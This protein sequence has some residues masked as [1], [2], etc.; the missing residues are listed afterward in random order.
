MKH[1]DI[2]RW[3]VWFLC[4]CLGMSCHVISRPVPREVERVERRVAAKPSGVRST[5]TAISFSYRWPEDESEE[6]TFYFVVP[7]GVSITPE[8]LSYKLRAAALGAR[9]DSG[10]SRMS[11]SSEPLLVET[12]VLARQISVKD[13]GFVRFNRLVEVRVEPRVRGVSAGQGIQLAEIEVALSF[14]KPY[15]TQASVIDNVLAESSWGFGRIL[16]TLV[17]N[18]EACRQY[19]TVSPP[20]SAELET[21]AWVPWTQARKGGPW[22]K[23]VIEKPGFYTIDQQFLQA[24]GLDPHTVHP[25]QVRIYNQGSKVPVH[26]AGGFAQTYTPNDHVVFYGVPSSSKYSGKN[27]YWVTL[28]KEHIGLEMPVVVQ[29]SGSAV[30]SQAEPFFFCSRVVEEDNELKMHTGRFLTIRE[31]QW[32]WK[33][34]TPDSPVTISFDLPGLYSMS[35]NLRIAVNLFFD[36]IFFTT[37][38]KVHCV[39]NGTVDADWVF[40]DI[41]DDQKY[42]QF[43][44]EA[45]REQGNTMRF[46]ETLEEGQEKPVRPAVYLDRIEFVYP[47]RFAAVDDAL[48]FTL[49]APSS[50]TVKYVRLT[51]FSSKPLL[52]FDITK[53]EQPQVIQ[54]SRH[55]DGSADLRIWV[56]GKRQ[57]EF[58]TLAQ[59][60]GAPL[61]NKPPALANLRSTMNGADYLIIAHENFLEVVNPLVVLK[62]AQ[63]LKTKLINVE[64]IYNEFNAGLESPVAIK[65]FLAYALRHWETRRPTYVLLVG[66]STSYYRG[67]TRNEAINYVPSFSYQVGA[68]EQDKWASDHWYTTVAGTDALADL[69]LGRLSVNSVED[70]QTVVE[71]IVHYSEQPRFGPWRTTLGYVADEGIFDRECEDLRTRYTPRTF[72]GETAYLGELPW[73][74]NFYLPL[75]MME[76]EKAKVSPIATARIL[77]MLNHGVL[78]LTFYGHGSPNVWTDEHIWFGGGSPNS[79][80]LHLRN[81]DV[82][83]FIINMTCNSG[84]IDYPVPPW[85]ICISEDFMRVKDGGAIGM[86]VPSGPGFTSTHKKV[87]ISLRQAFFYDGLRRLGDAIVS[88]NYSHLFKGHDENMVRMFILLGDPALELQVPAETCVLEVSE[89]VVRKGVSQQVEITGRTEGIN[90]GQVFYSVYTPSNEVFGEPVTESFA[91]G[92]LAYTFEVPETA[93]R[94]EWAVHAYCWNSEQGRDAMGAV[95]FA[96]DTPFVTLNSFKALNLPN[97]LNAGDLVELQ[98]TIQN[99]SAFQLPDVQVRVVQRSAGEEEKSQTRI[100]ALEPDQTQELRFH[101]TVAGGLNL[102]A[103]EVLNNVDPPDALT[104]TESQKTI[105]LG[106]KQAKGETELAVAGELCESEMTIAGARLRIQFRVPVF[107][108]GT[109]D[110]RGEVVLSDEE[111]NE[112]NRIARVFRASQTPHGEQVLIAT[113]ISPEQ[114]NQTL[115]F[116]VQME[117]QSG[118]E[119]GEMQQFRYTLDLR[120]LPDLVITADDVRFNNPNPTEGVTVF[121]HATVHNNGEA[122]AKDVRVTAYDGDP[123]GAGQ[124][125]ESFVHGDWGSLAYLAPGGSADVTLRWDPVKNVGEHEIFVKVDSSGRIS[126]SDESNNVASRPLRVKT[127]AILVPRGIIILEQT[128]EEREQHVARLAARVK[129]AGETAAHNVFVE[130]YSSYEQ[131]GENKLGQVII[132]EI[133]PAEIQMAIYRWQAREEDLHRAARPSYKIFLKGSL[134]RISSVDQEQ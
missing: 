86:Y 66:D 19:A 126:E 88:A 130:F 76:Q 123:E 12:P 28:D 70:A 36:P 127:K 30:P 78:F 117:D 25:R 133:R 58:L 71:K 40:A 21:Q 124:R 55:A 110:V 91:D 34:L 20:L 44:Y 5:A 94:G 49:D 98:A 77:D 56:Q 83:P 84:A 132:E 22:L 108:V 47:R 53:P 35:G 45:L 122:A 6:K 113:S 2:S 103:A 48:A 134:Q 50:G 18:P 57:Y 42:L 120:R 3:M 105:G 54:A 60:E 37:H 97:E 69:I 67:E 72:R 112:L 95:R 15:E 99:R 64:A 92:R 51:G 26:V 111:G 59:L 85:N 1:V 106:V 8:I 74:D 11:A 102:F 13:C 115:T 24:A 80:N 10:A 52:G 79:D 4:A 14:D 119:I 75:D 46:T 29:S 90:E 41:S 125:L 107:N 121:I 87:S 27:V 39:L 65:A 116:A 93:K 81:R 62:E 23:V 33:P 9:T 16:N 82:L 101:C 96:V 131:T 38:E 73:E 89:P 61:Q 31:M 63:G 104:E 7:V 43:P 118:E 129:N 114:A 100:V 32:V 68:T 109:K 128:L 17:A